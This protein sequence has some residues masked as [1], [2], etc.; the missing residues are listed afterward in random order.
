MLSLQGLITLFGPKL[1]YCIKVDKYQT[2]CIFP[3]VCLE[4]QTMIEL[5]DILFLYFCICLEF[6][7][8]WFFIAKRKLLFYNLNVNVVISAISP[9]GFCS[10]RLGSSYFNDSLMMQK[11]EKQ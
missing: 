7:P 5:H 1:F 10:S 8:K 11:K 6:G 2:W 4:N 3:S 9:V